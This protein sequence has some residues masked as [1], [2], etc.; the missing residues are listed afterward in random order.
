MIG[1]SGIIIVTDVVVEVA[2]GIAAR[3][4]LLFDQYQACSYFK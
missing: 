3:I 4:T 2:V 1:T